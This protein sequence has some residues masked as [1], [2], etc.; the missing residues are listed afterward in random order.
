MKILESP[1]TRRQTNKRPPIDSID[2]VAFKAKA[3]C[4]DV[5]RTSFLFTDI[6]RISLFIEFLPSFAEDRSNPG[7]LVR[8]QN[9]WGIHCGQF[10]EIINFNS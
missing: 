2:T 10:K 9:F 8:T 4:R 1:I 7:M 3:F 6:Q 5:R